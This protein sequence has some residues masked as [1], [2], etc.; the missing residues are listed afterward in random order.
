MSV[1]RGTR[2]GPYEILAPIG[3]GG[4]GEVYRARDTRLERTIAVKI[5]SERV[6]SR[7]ESRERFER[8]A[9][10]VA[11]LTHP[12]ICALHDVGEQDGVVFLVMEYLEGETLARRLARGALPLADVLRHSAEIAEALAEAHRH[13][14][15]HR[16]L[17]PANVMLTH[18]GAKLLDFGLAKLR[19]S[20]G[21]M[22][23]NEERTLTAEN[24]LVGTLPYMA[25]E[26]LEGAAVDART[27]IFALGAL[28]YE[29][30]TGVRAFGGS[31]QAS[32]VASIM[33]GD[34]PSLAS[35][36]PVA[37]RALERLVRQ[38]LRKDPG[39][40]WQSAHDVALRL[41]ELAVED[42]G[43][44]WKLSGRSLPRWRIPALGAALLLAALAGV[45]A[46]RAWRTTPARDA[47]RA[48]V[49]SSV[50]LPS[51]T[52]LTDGGVARTQL[53]LSPDGRVLVWSAR[54]TS[55]PFSAA[56]Y[57]RPLDRD[58]VK[59]IPGTT[60]ADQP[61]FSPDG[62]WVG[63]YDDSRKRL[64][65]IPVEGGLA[66]DLG[67]SDVWGPMGACWTADGKIVLGH[68]GKGLDWIPAEGGAPRVLTTVDR[69]REIGHRLPWVLP[70]GKA[71][72][73]TTMPHPWGVRARVE[74]VSLASGV[75]KV[76]VEDAADGRY[77]ASG[78]LVFA[79]Q[80]VLMAAPF[81]PDRL[82]LEGPPVPV[83]D[84]V[85]QSLNVDSSPANSG[86][87][88]FAV[89]AAGL[90]VYATG[91]FLNDPPAEPFLVDRG[92]RA[93][94]LA[95]FDKPKISSQVHF[96][97]DGRQVAFCE[98]ARSGLAWVFDVE[99][100]THRP[101]SHDGIAGSLIWSPDGTR[102]ALTWS[103]AGPMSLWLAPAEGGG[104]WQ[105]L[106]EGDDWPSSWTPDGRAVVFVRI[107]PDQ[108]MDILLYRFEDRQ[109]VPLLATKANEMFPEVSPDGRW[110][111]YVSDESGRDEVL[112]TSFPDRKTTF[113]VSREGADSPAW[114][115]DGKT[116]YYLTREFVDNGGPA[117]R[118]LSV[119]VTPGE[120]LAL[121]KPAVLFRLP[122]GILGSAPTRCYDIHP[123]G[124][125]FLFVRMKG[126]SSLPAPVT[127]LHLAQDWFAELERLSPTE[128]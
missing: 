37:P 89:S 11:S 99:R 52:E 103:V 93:E 96:S 59:L 15:V 121:G 27:D 70:G 107:Q 57:E 68:E 122:P 82:E 126:S 71:I 43:A 30:T 84:D 45:V 42:P 1:E 18:A 47:G 85:R 97:P 60:G 119:P 101:L 118:L 80:G 128:R 62:R 51:G 77:L 127:R 34:V 66:V 76:L 90:L 86:A 13:G 14:V 48:I 74:A 12:H 9:R 104:P 117:Y 6:S 65:K 32:L 75:R 111:A 10:T 73:F 64:R 55:A 91:G 33:R 79:R 81:D 23:A 46:G 110:L 54:A 83:L 2:F 109:V 61:F 25:P 98:R 95:G 35:S 56:L 72:L 116:L 38:C 8:E 108:T 50:D 44:E 39:E 17:K 102:I 112:V 28:I 31:S 20:E 40:R 63:F 24:A 5:L 69:A 49:R 106:T 105:R 120:P 16:D 88:Q 7:P 124:R 4:M 19:P 53:A 36:Q 100:Q 67:E 78:H 123:V 29:M 115:R 22:G 26:Q 92:G 94:P 113:V 21:V 58:E 114:S 3:A 41:R 87:A 125:R